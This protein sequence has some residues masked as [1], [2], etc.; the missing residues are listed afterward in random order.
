MPGFDPTAEFDPLNY[1]VI[2]D[3]VVSALLRNPLQLLP[4]AEAFTGS[5]VYLL[6]YNGPFDAYTP[7]SGKD[8]PIYVGRAIPKGGRRG[9][10][11]LRQIEHSNDPALFNRLRDHTQSIDAAENLQLADFRCRYLVV[12][13]IWIGIVE[14][15]LIEKFNPVW[16]AAVD[17]FGL[18][19]P[20]TTRFTQKRSDWDTLHPGRSWTPM[21]AEGKPVEQI[22][23]AIRRHFGLE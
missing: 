7:I 5:G 23:A 19:H 9:T 14:S 4:L 1:H 17:G 10:A 22:L 18:H 8:I 20:G 3:T 13:Q 6:Y 21:M 16:N 12:T 2:A 15:L 11:A